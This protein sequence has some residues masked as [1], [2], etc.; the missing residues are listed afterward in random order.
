MAAVYAFLITGLVDRA[1][2]IQGLVDITIKS[3]INSAVVLFIIQTAS[4]FSW[5]LTSE[6][7]PHLIGQLSADFSQSK[8]VFLLMTNVIL[9]IAGCLLTGTATVAI[10]API[11]LPVA[12]SYGIDPIFLGALMVVN[13]AIGYITPPVGVDLYVAASIAKIPVGSVIRKVMPYLILLL[14]NLL[15]IT[16]FPAMT[17]WLPNLMK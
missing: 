8:V 1:L 14:I 15:I 4:A 9:L 6:R 2:S 16:F 7:V 17:M 12:I 13:L 3:V 10:L 11:L 5:I